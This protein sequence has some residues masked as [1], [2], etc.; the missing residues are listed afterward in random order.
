MKRAAGWR[1]LNGG[2]REAT[3]KGWILG[4][5]LVSWGWV[6]VTAGGARLGG[7]GEGG[8]SLEIQAVC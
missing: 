1:V 5:V 8:L 6:A 3:G 4:S 7:R 2:S